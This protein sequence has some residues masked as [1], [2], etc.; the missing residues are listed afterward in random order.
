MR[1]R[2]G[3]SFM[4]LCA[5]SVFPDRAVLLENGGSGGEAGL[6]AGGSLVSGGAPSGEAGAGGSGLSHAGESGGVAEGGMSG[7]VAEGG[8]S[9]GVAE[10]GVAGAGGSDAGLCPGALSHVLSPVSDAWITEADGKGNFGS[11]DGLEVGNLTGELSHALVRFDLSQFT[12]LTQ[13]SSAELSL[14]LRTSAGEARRIG[15]HR[16]SREWREDRV[17]WQQAAPSQIWTTPGGDAE[18]VPIDNALIALGTSAGTRISWDV[19][20][21]VEADLARGGE[22]FGWLLK[23]VEPERARLRLASREFGAAPPVLT[24]ITCP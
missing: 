24:V 23:E 1:G 7:G 19:R 5:C 12:A 17:S 2:L 16:L 8:V 20:I 9:G 18:R 13:V 15:A 21:D 3:A 11:A 14:E 4:V 22:S 10:G 6:A